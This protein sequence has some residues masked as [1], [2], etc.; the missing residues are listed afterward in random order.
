MLDLVV[1]VLTDVLA[2]L[3]S[4]LGTL[5]SQSYLLGYCYDTVGVLV[6]FCKQILLLDIRFRAV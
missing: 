6:I 4:L 2:K 3:N 1:P 5:V